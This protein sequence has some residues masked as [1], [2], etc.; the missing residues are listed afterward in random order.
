MANFAL[1]LVAGAALA[2]AL[3]APAANTTSAT[4]ATQ[5]P[6]TSATN[7]TNATSAANATEEPEACRTGLVGQIREMVPD[8]IRACP[9]SCRSLE[10][11]IQVYLAQLSELEA[12]RV[13]CNHEEDFRCFLSPEHLATCA[14]VKEKAAS[15]GY[16]L[17]G[18]VGELQARCREFR[19][20]PGDSGHRRLASLAETTWV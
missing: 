8:C 12:R 9:E 10:L 13:M 1:F 7:A 2:V 15:M 16:K 14:R 20:L 3:E 6:N 5:A 11:S 17:P 4:N 18:D 19:E